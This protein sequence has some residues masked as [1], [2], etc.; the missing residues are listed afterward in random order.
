MVWARAESGALGRCTGPGMA[1]RLPGHLGGLVLQARRWAGRRVEGFEAEQENKGDAES[2]DGDGE[3]FV[4]DGGR[5]EM[6]ARHQAAR[7]V[8]GGGAGG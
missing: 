6:Q 5:F 3:E 4:A 1:A 8:P 2:F 7:G